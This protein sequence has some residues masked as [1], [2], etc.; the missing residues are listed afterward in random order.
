MGSLHEVH[1]SWWV[2]T[3]HADTS[4]SSWS[5]SETVFDV[6]VVGGGITGLSTALVLAERGAQVVVLE[7]DALC[8]GATGYTTAK[9]TS[10]HGLQ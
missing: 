2:A 7:A 9:V 10:L 4:Y 3:T 6:A 5:G 1:P 8:S